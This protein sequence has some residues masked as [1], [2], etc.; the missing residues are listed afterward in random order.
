[1]YTNVYAPQQNDPGEMQAG[2]NEPGARHR[3]DST[4]SETTSEGGIFRVLLVLVCPRIMLAWGSVF[5]TDD[6]RKNGLELL[7]LD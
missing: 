3:K 4:T 1:M 7:K 5:P 2:F 6:A